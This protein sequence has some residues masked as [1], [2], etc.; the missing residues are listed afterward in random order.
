MFAIGAFAI[1][2]DEQNRVLLA[3]RRDMDV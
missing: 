1:I 2:L 3:H